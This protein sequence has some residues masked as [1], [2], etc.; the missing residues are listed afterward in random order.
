MASEIKT[1]LQGLVD[2]LKADTTLVEYLGEGTDGSA[3]IYDHQHPGAVVDG[4]ARGAVM[5]R[6]AGCGAEA[7]EDSCPETTVLPVQIEVDVWWRGTWEDTL[8]HTESGERSMLDLVEAV[9]TAIRTALHWDITGTGNASS[10]IKDW[11]ITGI[12]APAETDYETDRAMRATI[13]ITAN[14]MTAKPYI[15][16]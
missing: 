12:T 2:I 9:L 6:W 10:V 16:A 7:G 5:V 11:W 4:T 8:A 1:V 13:T 15:D 14:A 3:L